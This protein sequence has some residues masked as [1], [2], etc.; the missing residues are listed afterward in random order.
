MSLRP[1]VGRH[2]AVCVCVCVCVCESECVCVSA[3][4]TDVVFMHEL[5]SSVCLSL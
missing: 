3:A 4:Q 2:V 5:L 1:A